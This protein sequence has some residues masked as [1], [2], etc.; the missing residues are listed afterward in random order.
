MSTIDRHR[1]HVPGAGHADG[2]LLTR[3]A[4]HAPYR[5]GDTVSV[6]AAVRAATARPPSP[7]GTRSGAGAVVGSRPTASSS[8]TDV[9]LASSRAVMARPRSRSGRRPTPGTGGPRS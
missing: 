2:A 5:P 6:D 4:Q 8:T 9:P 1:R 7:G 3:G